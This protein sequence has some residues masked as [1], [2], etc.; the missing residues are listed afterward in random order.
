MAVYGFNST[1]PNTLFFLDDTISL[2]SNGFQ[3]R[4]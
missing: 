2:W 1:F 3:K 4:N